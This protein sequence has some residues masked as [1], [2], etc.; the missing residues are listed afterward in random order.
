MGPIC[1]AFEN[2]F[3]ITSVGE[4]APCCVYQGSK[5]EIS[6]RVSQGK[7]DNFTFSR[8]QLD[9]SRWSENG[10]CQSCFR[11]EGKG[12]IS[13][14]DKLLSRRQKS[15]ELQ[16][17]CEISF[18][19]QCNLDCIMCSAVYSQKML[20]IHRKFLQ[21]TFADLRVEHELMI[22]QSISY[23]LDLEQTK[24]LAESLPS[25]DSIELV[26]GEPFAFLHL[27]I[28][29]RYLKNKPKILRIVSNGTLINFE[30]L[31]IVSSWTDCRFEISLSVDGVGDVYRYVRG[32]PFERMLSNF[33]YYRDLTHV[34]RL[35]IKPTL[36]FMNYDQIL[37]LLQWLE[38]DGNHKVIP[39]FDQFLH[40]DEALSPTLLPIDYRKELRARLETSRLTSGAWKERVRPT[41]VQLQNYPMA[42]AAQKSRA[43]EAIRILND[44]RNMNFWEISPDLAQAIL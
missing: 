16:K 18:S 14:R 12:L 26:G 31:D 43:L 5:K 15:P 36:G 41:L 24:I 3:V 17:H 38:N 6:N 8:E 22:N 35:F 21:S 44:H 40:Y 20:G 34:H 28:F 32:V 10:A 9:P 13:K 1:P 33:Q 7:R 30:A 11:R 19:N 2:E 37:P 4:I 25:Y 39:L 29:L 27:P 42:S 23:N